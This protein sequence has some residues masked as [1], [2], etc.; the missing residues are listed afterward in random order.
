MDANDDLRLLFQ[1]GMDRIGTGFKVYADFDIPLLLYRVVVTREGV[2]IRSGF[3]LEP[4]HGRRYGAEAITP[5]QVDV[6]CRHVADD[7]S[8]KGG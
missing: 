5:V 7:L 8:R 4:Q 1:E 2:P 6:R 3:Y